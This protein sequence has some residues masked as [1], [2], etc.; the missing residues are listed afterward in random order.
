MNL[1]LIIE[2]VNSI[3]E[4]YGETDPERLCGDLNVILMYEPM[5]A[6]KN[7]CKGFFFHKN[8]VGVITVNSEL[9][10]SFRRIITAHELGHAVLH[11]ETGERGFLDSGY[12][13]EATDCE[14]EANLFAAELLISDRDIIEY[15]EECETYY[16]IASRLYVPPQLVDLKLQIM[17]HKGYDI[18]A[19]KETSADFMGKMEV[20]YG[21]EF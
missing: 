6:S 12:F 13:D 15:A 1:D 17:E 5:G 7:S 3:R 19:P 16:E 8:G 10:D 4:K 11:A 21:E 2:K 18:R 14:R 20:R 9:T